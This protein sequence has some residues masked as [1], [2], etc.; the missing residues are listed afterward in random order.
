MWGINKA[1]KPGLYKMP[2]IITFISHQPG[3]LSQSDNWDLV[4]DEDLKIV[5][6][7]KNY[8]LG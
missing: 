5:N 2:I 3:F 6:L 1:E 7:A 4:V 8:H